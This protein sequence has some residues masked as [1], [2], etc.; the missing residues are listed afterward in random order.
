[1]FLWI[2]V[3]SLFC[4]Y[5]LVVFTN[6]LTSDRKIRFKLSVKSEI[7]HKNLNIFQANFAFFLFLPHLL[8]GCPTANFGPLSR[9]QPHCVFQFRPEGHRE[10]RSSKGWVPSP[11]ERLV[12]VEP[13]TLRFISLSPTSVRK[14][15]GKLWEGNTGLKWVTL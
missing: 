14:T 8:F 11:A 12:G 2:S 15:R 13:R 3:I 6:L 7:S 10:R 1:M 9:G 5:F 4:S